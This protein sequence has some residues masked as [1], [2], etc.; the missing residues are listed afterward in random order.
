MRGVMDGRV[1]FAAAVVLFG[2]ASLYSVLLWRRGFSRD[3]WW[4]YGFL[5]GSAVPLTGALLARGFSLQRCPVTNLFEATMFVAWAILAAHLVI[6]LW[7]RLRFLAAFSAPLLLA[8][9]IFGLQPRL[10]EPG[11]ILDTGHGL[12][13]L[14]VTLILLGYGA[15]GL[16]AMAAVMYLVQERDLKLHKL[17]AVIARL[18]A[19]ERLEKVM[20]QASASGLVLLSVGLAVSVVLVRQSESAARAVRGDP[21][22]IW[23]LLV[24]CVYLG[25]LVTRGWLNRGPRWLAWSSVGVFAFVMLTFWGTNLLSPLHQQ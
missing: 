12:L 14:H 4:C 22:V 15:F 3:D 16:S 5:A 24:W 8:L 6:G 23:S 7:S 18:P 20:V 9:G 19:I 21:K 13:S 1:L 10:D 25:M 17:R 2:A 11:P